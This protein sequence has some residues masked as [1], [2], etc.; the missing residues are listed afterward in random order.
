MAFKI[1]DKVVVAPTDKSNWNSEGRMEASVGMVG[2]IVWAWPRAFE[3]NF[4]CTDCDTRGVYFSWYYLPQD[5]KRLYKFKGN[6]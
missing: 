2:T 3:V 5:I 4:G 1:G 6:K